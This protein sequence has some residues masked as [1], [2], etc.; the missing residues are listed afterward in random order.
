MRRSGRPS[1]APR[2]PPFLASRGYTGTSRGKAKPLMPLRLW[3][4]ASAGRG[5]Q[6]R[7]RLLSPSPTHDE[8]T[9]QPKA[10][11]IVIVAADSKLA[12]VAKAGVEVFRLEEA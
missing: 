5:V 1:T 10:V 4:Y 3:G 7:S 9:F 11:L 12:I 6:F 8:S 2:T